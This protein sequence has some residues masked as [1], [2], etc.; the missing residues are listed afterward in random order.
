MEL[1]LC[2]VSSHQ[3]YIVSETVSFLFIFKIIV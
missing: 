2:I 1:F 3:N